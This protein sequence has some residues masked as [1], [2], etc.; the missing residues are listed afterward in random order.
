M[1]YDSGYLSILS[2]DDAPDNRLYLP[3]GIKFLIKM[4]SERIIFIPSKGI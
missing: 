2:K 4:L 3:E 1:F